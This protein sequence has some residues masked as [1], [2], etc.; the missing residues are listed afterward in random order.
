[1]GRGHAHQR[2]DIPRTGRAAWSAIA[3]LRH[4]SPSFH[5]RGL[6]RR[7]SS[8]AR[9]PT[10]VDPRIL[11]ERCLAGQ[12]A[13]WDA[14]VE[15]YHRLVWSV[16]HACRLPDEDCDDVV[17]AVFMAALRSLEQLRDAERVT[18]WLLTCAH[19][20]SWRLARQR[21]RSVNLDAD[22][23]SVA[24]PAPDRAEEL[25]SRQAVREALDALGEPCRSLLQALY[26]ADTP[27]YPTIAAQLGMPVGSIGPRR[28]RCLERLRQALEQAGHG[29]DPS[30]SGA[31]P[32][33]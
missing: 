23:P 3:G 20:E 21:E 29:P 6:G 1:M 11:V 18:S 25:E 13:A 4:R 2:A 24:E 28:G 10:A 9:V 17:Q 7:V 5:R 32:G 14:F 12:P 27:H 19:R 31:R 16:P 22:F 8:W 15:R 33:N 30:P 26:A